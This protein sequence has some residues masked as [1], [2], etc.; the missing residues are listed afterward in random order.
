MNS[1]LP[2]PPP[3][4]P[5]LAVAAV[6]MGTCI[7]TLN[8]R[9]T[10]F[11]LGDI[12]GALHGGFD[13]GSWIP[14][15]QTAAQML[16]APFAIWAG[17]AFGPRRVLMHAAA[18]FSLL[19]IA[20]PF[21]T[22][23]TTFLAMQFLSGLASGFFVPLTLGFLMRSL[24][25]RYWAFG[26]AA[27]ALNLELSL[28][29]SASIEGWFVDTLSWRW[30]FW[31]NVPLAVLM[32][33][34]L[35]VEG[36]RDEIANPPAFD[37]FGV[38]ASGLGLALIYAGLDQG[39]RLDWFNS[40]LVTGLLLAGAVL[41][42]GFLL[43][44]ANAANHFINLGFVFSRPILFLLVLVC[45]L[46]FTTLGTSFLVPQ[47]LQSVRGYRAIEIGQTLRWIAAPQI[48]I[49]PLTA[50]LLRRFDSRL[51][52]GLGFILIGV[53]CLQVADGLTP[54]WGTDQFVLSQVLQATGQAMAL[55]G[56]I[57]LGVLHLRPAEALSFGASFQ[58]ARLLGG[59]IGLAAIATITRVQMQTASQTI[60]NHVQRGDGGVLARLKEYGSLSP[61]ESD[62]GAA[63]ARGTAILSN[64]VR[65]AA[66]TQGVIDGF[67]SVG[68]AA[69]V[70]LIVAV[71]HSTA[72]EGPAS[73]VPPRLWRRAAR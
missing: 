43:H 41:F 21:A 63:L 29:I 24:P 2:A 15:A 27:Y 56:V 36:K 71:A 59:E 60:G 53:A 44:E 18:A 46:R 62:P 6:L 38:S 30:I 5:W 20:A 35:A 48:L 31:Q 47:F 7:S 39:N 55:S 42:L 1:P 52:A 8:G 72:P 73:H 58:V 61:A 23:F 70:A 9:F 65:G 40:G 67:L 17:G 45:L 37:P 25:P 4:I 69:L 54:I 11:G 16:V 13:E 57:F 26:V 34:F 49:C 28:N 64:A 33:A 12:R 51:V 3:P 14:T 19:S 68:A 22:G 50:F 66:T 32:A 10:S